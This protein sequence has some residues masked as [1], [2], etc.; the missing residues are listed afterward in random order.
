MD[1]IDRTTIALRLLLT[2][3]G[4]EI[5]ETNPQKPNI[6]LVS[7]IISLCQIVYPLGYEF[8]LKYI[9]GIP[10]I[11]SERLTREID[12]LFNRVKQCKLILVK[13]RYKVNQEVID[14]ILFIKDKINPPQHI[15]V[16]RRMWLF[17]CGFYNELIKIDSLSHENINDIFINS[18][19]D[20]TPYIG[21]IEEALMELET[22]KQI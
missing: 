8:E 3:F 13:K 19:K 2:E 17:I 9:R 1:S 7:S 22:T 18:Y 5:D 4:L 21:Y 11:R 10:R 6:D 12:L 16:S 20:L 15:N 14:K